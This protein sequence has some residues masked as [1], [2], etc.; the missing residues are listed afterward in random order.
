ML[1]TSYNFRQFLNLKVPFKKFQDAR[2]CG[3]RNQ[4]GKKNNDRIRT[5]VNIIMKVVTKNKSMEKKY[6]KTMLSQKG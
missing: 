1:S 4:Q 3:T 5:P 6:I 2:N